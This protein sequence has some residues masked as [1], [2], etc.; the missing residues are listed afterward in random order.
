MP[1]FKVM[2]RLLP[3]AVVTAAF[4]A[5]ASSARE[6]DAGLNGHDSKAPVDYAAD[7]IELQDKQNRVYLSGNVDV[8]QGDLRLQADRTVVAYINQDGIKIKRLDATSNVVVTR[9]D[10]SATANIANYDFEKRTIIL[11]GNVVLRR[12]KDISR[13]E[14]LVIDLNAH[15]SGFVGASGP[16]SGS[17]RVTG[18]FSVAK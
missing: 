13:G 15:H 1:D 4:C 10:E 12:N 8:K 6:G 14:R 11:V 18:T 16:N 9:G 3:V 7:R 17:Q 2:L 5:D